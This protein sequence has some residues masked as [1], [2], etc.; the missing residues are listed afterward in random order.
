MV[1]ILEVEWICT[2][3]ST[4]TCITIVSSLVPLVSGKGTGLAMAVLTG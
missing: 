1:D 2:E 3:N 4:P